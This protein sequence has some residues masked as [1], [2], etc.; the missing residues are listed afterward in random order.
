MKSLII[1]SALVLLILPVQ[2]Q[3]LEERFEKLEDV[4]DNLVSE[5]E[6]LKSDHQ[7]HKRATSGSAVA[8]SAHVNY[9]DSLTRGQVIVFD[10]VQTNIGNAYDNVQGKFT[11]PVDGVYFFTV[12]FLS[13]VNH[14]LEAFIKHAGTS[15][16][17]I[18]TIGAGSGIDDQSTNSVVVHCTK[19][20]QV[21]VESENNY[22]INGERVGFTL[23]SG[24]L[25]SADIENEVV[26]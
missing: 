11:C 8:F 14:L 21:W 6:K 1:I 10:T 24:F 7:I 13:H 3:S 5:M 23:F 25:I 17:G 19:G 22:L 15:V 9:D 20:Q 12:T 16:A 4:V 26:G 2:T 18:Y